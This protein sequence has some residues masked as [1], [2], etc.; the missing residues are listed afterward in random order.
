MQI[1]AKFL[2]LRPYIQ[3]LVLFLVL[4]LPVF[5]FCGYTDIRGNFYAWHIFGIP[6]ADPLN[7]VQG[8]LQGIINGFW[9]LSTVF[10]GALLSLILA[11]FCGRIFCSWLC[12]Y[13]LLSELVWKI[14]TNHSKRKSKA[15]VWRWRIIIV[16]SGLLLG[17]ILGIPLLNH[18]SVPGL[19]S[20]APQEFWQVML[21]SLGLVHSGVETVLPPA[22]TPTVSPLPNMLKMIAFMIGPVALLLCLELV[23][24][25]RFWC[26]YACP[27]ALLLMLSSRLGYLSPIPSLHISWR[28][29]HCNCKGGAHPCVDSCSLGLNPRTLHK[30]NLDR[31]ACINCG[32]CV[33]AC[34]KTNCNHEQNAL[35]LETKGK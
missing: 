23:L 15:A 6:F 31:D 1:S 7:A 24:K 21:P 13:G 20:L 12:P 28:A 25:K 16:L 35:H 18:L 34:V 2:A 3:T 26:S 33:K 17:F 5:Y 10:I 29:D 32:D 11:L 22:I 9:P 19:I 27:Q 30:K 4:L 8:L 14:T